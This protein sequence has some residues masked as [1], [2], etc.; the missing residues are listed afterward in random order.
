MGRSIESILRFLVEQRL[1]SIP[2]AFPEGHKR[3]FF[4][5]NLFPAL[6]PGPTPFQQFR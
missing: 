6:P 1:A 4:R 2:L 5:V 3:A